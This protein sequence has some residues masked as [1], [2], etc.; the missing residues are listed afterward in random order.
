[1]SEERGGMILLISYCNKITS[2]DWAE[3]FSVMVKKK[4]NVK[5][6]SPQMHV[7]SSAP[8]PGPSQLSVEAHFLL[9]LSTLKLLLQQTTM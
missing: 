9:M 2:S 6:V 4:K 8:P 3:L 1:M 5:D 7:S